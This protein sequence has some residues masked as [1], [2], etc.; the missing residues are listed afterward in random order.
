LISE[1]EKTMV[2]SALLAAVAAVAISSLPA[3]AA[4]PAPAARAVTA[5]IDDGVSPIRYRRHRGFGRGVGVGIGIGVLGAIIADQAYRGRPA[6]ADEVEAYDGPPDAGEVGD[7]RSLCAETFR[8][9]EWNT[10][11]YTTYAGEKRL[12]PY[13]R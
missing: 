3:I 2:K 11:L 7:P 4:P 1:P 8:S 5:G 9:F 12:C 6:Y 10:G 13:L